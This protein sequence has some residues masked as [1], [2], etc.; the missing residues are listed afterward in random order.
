MLEFPRPGGLT[1]V[2]VGAQLLFVSRH[3][4]L[5]EILEY[6]PELNLDDFAF[7]QD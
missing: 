7:D 4:Q 3:H 2:R 5:D 6:L 1:C